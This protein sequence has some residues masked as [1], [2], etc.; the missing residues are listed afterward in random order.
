MKLILIVLF[1]L[2]TSSIFS[3]ATEQELVIELTDILSRDGKLSRKDKKFIKEQVKEFRMNQVYDKQ[4]YDE[5]KTYSYDNVD[6]QPY[7]GYYDKRYHP[8]YNDEIRRREYNPIYRATKGLD[9]GYQTGLSS[10]QSNISYKVGRTLSK[11]VGIH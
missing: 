2:L 1:S 3:Q 8:S 6:N 4:E 11:L 9:Y 10:L 7:D 5:Y